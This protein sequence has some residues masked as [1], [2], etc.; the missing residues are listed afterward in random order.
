[1]PTWDAGFTAAYFDHSGLYAFG[2]QPEALHWNC[3]QLAIALRQLSDAPPLVAA[4]ERFAGLYRSNL[5]RR[6]GWRLG[7]AS[8][9]EEAD[10]AV[11][12]ASEKTLRESGV[13]VDEF[14]F[15]HRGGRAVGGDLAVALAGF[16]G[17]FAHP[18]WDEPE[19]QSLLI[20]EV[21]AIWAAIAERDDWTPLTAK[22]A[23]LKRMGE[24]LGEPPGPAAQPV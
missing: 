1:M 10:L 23:T 24:A 17:D 16:E 11:V 2:R 12:V 21:E 8:R 18:Y 20:D 4:L 7:L 15:R 5:A 3:S 13:G 19:P 14:F 6:F 22:L 9:G